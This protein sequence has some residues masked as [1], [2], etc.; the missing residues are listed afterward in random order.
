ML[1]NTNKY[2]NEMRRHKNDYLPISVLQLGKRIDDILDMEGFKVIRDL[3]RVSK[4]QVCSLPGMGKQSVNNLANQMIEIGVRMK[5]KDIRIGKYCPKTMLLL[6]TNKD[7]KMLLLSSK[8]NRDTERSVFIEILRKID[9]RIEI[10]TNEYHFLFCMLENSYQ[11]C[12]SNNH[13]IEIRKIERLLSC[14]IDLLI[15]AKKRH[16]L[17][18]SKRLMDYGMKI[19][20]YCN[21]AQRLRKGSEG[22]FIINALIRFNTQKKLE[23][24]ILFIN[25]QFPVQSSLIE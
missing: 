18:P 8:G 2:T 21:S 24:K 25:Y 14:L 12:I 11:H 20:S 1:E 16:G 9:E 3:R 23:K 22:N 19:S 13:I 4:S 10:E 6:E 7:L 5:V 17:I 15:R